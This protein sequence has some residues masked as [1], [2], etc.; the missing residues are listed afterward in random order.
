MAGVGYAVLRVFTD[1]PTRDATGI[2][3]RCQVGEVD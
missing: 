2:R 1:H 3:S